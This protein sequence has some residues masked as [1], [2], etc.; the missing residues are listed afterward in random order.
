MQ[1]SFRSMLK[2]TPEFKVTRRAFLCQALAGI[3][4]L[5]LPTILR[6][7][8]Q[9]GTAAARSDTSLIFLWQ[10]GGPSHFET[11]DPKPLAPAEVR[12]E[13]QAIPTSL[14][15]V[16]FC[17]VLPRLARLAGKLTIV[18]SLHQPHSGHPDGSRYFLT[19]YVDANST[20]GSAY[21]DLGAVIHRLRSQR[22]GALPEYVA[23]GPYAPGLHRGGPAYLGAAYKPFVA[24]GDPAAPDFRIDHFRPHALNSGVRLQER[25]LLRAR[26]DTMASPDHTG[27]TEA[28]DLFRRRSLDLLTSPAATA[29]F[30]LDREDRRTRERYGLN[31]AGQQALHARRLVEAGV[32]VVAV[33]FC[34]DARGDADRS[35]VGWDDH[36]VHG[37][38]FTV[39]R[40]RGPQF[41]QA[42][43]ALIE[44]LAQRGLDRNV[45]LVVAGEFGR[46]PRISYANGETFN[47]GH[48]PGRDHWGAAGC[49]LVF[50]GGMPMGQVIGA[51]NRLGEFPIDRAVQP[52]DLLA[53]IY[54]FLGINPEHQ[55]V[56]H[57]GRPIAVLPFGTPIRELDCR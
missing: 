27:Q 41:D 44:D 36:A 37:N 46:T 18:R 21:P 33:R 32:S 54:R 26:F 13:L 9:A 1:T 2:A 57:S 7:R 16:Q 10:D 15:G 23:M 12:G 4:T 49:A 22:G 29:A 31:T 39:M 28:T 34:P 43:S 19:G 56:N 51:T 50:G 11:F 30:D 35:G 25:Q 55:F 6:L 24:Q 47:T 8:A 3:G 40:R 20:G 48:G 38:I 5:N 17:E 53:T 45:L 14:A 52:Q 42:V